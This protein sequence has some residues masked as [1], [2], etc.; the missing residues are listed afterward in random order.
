MTGAILLSA[1]QVFLLVLFAFAASVGNF[2]SFILGFLKISICVSRFAPWSMYINQIWIGI[3]YVIFPHGA[4]LVW[5]LIEI[6]CY[7]FQV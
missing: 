2:P 6:F 5:S 7:L 4:I 3:S 1:G